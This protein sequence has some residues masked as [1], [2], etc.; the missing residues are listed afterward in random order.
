MR[1][2]PVE[3]TQTIVGSFWNNVDRYPERNALRHREGSTWISTTWADYGAAVGAVA[4]GLRLLGVG[5]GDRVA[6]VSDNRIEWHIAD[7]AVMS[8][9]A[10][11]VP[12]YQTSSPPQLRHALD[13]SGSCVVFV[14]TA[15]QL[16]K[17]GTICASLPGLR[18]VIAIEPVEVS[19]VLSW[20]EVLGVGNDSETRDESRLDDIATIVYTSG[21]TGTAKG[22]ALTHRNIAFTVAS[23]MSVVELNGGDRFLSFLPLS[24]IAERA[25][26]HFGQIA[27]GG[28]TWFARGTATVAEDLQACRPT[29]FFGVPRIWEKFRDAI[30]DQATTRGI[31]QRTALQRYLA[32][33]HWRSGNTVGGP[34]LRA[35]R[36][37]SWVALDRVVGRTLRREL[38]LDQA[39]LLVSG[40]APIDA[41]LVRWFVGIGLPITPA[42]GQTE[43]CGP[44]TLGNSADLDNS[45][46]GSVGRALPG[47]G[48][49]TADDG[50]LLVRGACVCDGYWNNERATAEL[51]DG[52]GWMHTG[53]LARI[54]PDGL[55][56]IVGRKK[57]LIVLAAG[58]KVVPTELESRLRREP[59]VLEAVIVGEGRPYLT[60]LIT[61]NPQRLAA[62]AKA[63]HKL[64]S[65]EALA[66]D[67]DVRAAITAAVADLNEEVARSETIK[68]FRILPLP[69]TVAEGELTPTAKVKRNVVIEHNRA[70]ID[71][72]YA[73]TP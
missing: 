52:D 4:H 57:D 10:I 20:Q 1:Q 68:H 32:A 22:A 45:L 21:T 73:G 48:L 55:V 25:V 46:I 69:F 37:T 47:V 8:I 17:I 54:D 66:V 16:A 71:E 34:I 6:I 63:N 56:W 3:V 61:L 23:V 9:G 31:V 43:D 59:L 13:D 12:I 14:D 50:E 11:S 40:A 44:V 15:D 36:T 5:R 24:H 70:L 49:M 33:G 72:M 29:V 65:S 42:Y 7:L 38:G 60:A 26:S 58:H 62:W 30:E 35:A 51:I 53:D 19:G 41:A 28:E 64:H 18:H 67:S 27:G 2:L 39:R